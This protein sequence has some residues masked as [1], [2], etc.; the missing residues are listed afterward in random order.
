MRA[1]H[2]NTVPDVRK[3]KS[4]KFTFV[5]KQ[6]Y[7]TIFS[8]IKPCAVLNSW[9][10][11]WIKTILTECNVSFLIFTILLNFIPRKNMAANI[12]EKKN[13]FD[14]SWIPTVRTTIAT[15]LCVTETE[16]LTNFFI[17]LSICKK[18]LS[19]STSILLLL[20]LLHSL[21]RQCTDYICAFITQLYFPSLSWNCVLLFAIIRLYYRSSQTVSTGCSFWSSV[22]CRLLDCRVTEACWLGKFLAAI[23]DIEYQKKIK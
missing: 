7:F 13:H 5:Q 19:P 22:L 17:S 2:Y 1:V 8:R 16:L 12:R 15:L 18:L 11:H 14:D 21:C 3:H 10:F 9:Y 4:D 20:S 23:K 6:T